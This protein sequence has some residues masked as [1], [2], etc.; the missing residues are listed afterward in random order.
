MRIRGAVDV[1]ALA[2]GAA[3]LLFSLAAVPC[4]KSLDVNSPNQLKKEAIGR[5]FVKN[6][7]IDPC[8][9]FSSSFCATRPDRLIRGYRSLRSIPQ[10]VCVGF[11]RENPEG[12]KKEREKKENDEKTQI[13]R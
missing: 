5:T 12:M 11:W 1:L 3:F 7:V 10:V 8:A 2:A 13:E 9:F 6:A 4:T